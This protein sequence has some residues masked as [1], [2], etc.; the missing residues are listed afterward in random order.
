MC[1][2]GIGLLSIRKD[3]FVSATDSGMAEAGWLTT[4][5]LALPRCGSSQTVQ[6]LLNVDASISGGVRAELRDP[7]T[8]LPLPGRALADADQLKGSFIS[9]PASWG[10]GKE[11]SV[12]AKAGSVVVHLELEVTSLYSLQFACK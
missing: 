3:G 8:G 1:S 6:L 5:P 10:R 2:T 11:A 7:Q 9:H 12:P 4:K